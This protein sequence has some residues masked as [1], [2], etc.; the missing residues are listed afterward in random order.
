MNNYSLIVYINGDLF[1]INLDSLKLENVPNNCSYSLQKIDGITSS[2][3]LN[4]FKK[5]LNI[6]D[7]SIEIYVQNLRDFKILEPIFSNKEWK[8]VVSSQEKK[9]LYNKVVDDVLSSLTR[10]M[11]SFIPDKQI[12][13]KFNDSELD[14][15]DYLN[16]NIY[17]YFVKVQKY[18]TMKEPVHK[19]LATEEIS[20]YLMRIYSCLRQY[21][22]L[23]HLY[24]I[25][26]NNCKKREEVKEK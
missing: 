3:S 9:G 21:N 10:E 25:R 5:A 18:R 15:T 23:R 22:G 20:K 12:L 14:V 11:D 4:N 6:D 16:Y 1:Y 13:L 8:R 19:L 2:V 26:E 17:K 24:L 7:D